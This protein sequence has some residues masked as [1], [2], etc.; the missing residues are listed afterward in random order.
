M[1]SQRGFVG[2]NLHGLETR[3]KAQKSGHR[4][5]WLRE[6]LEIG[7]FRLGRS[8]HRHVSSGTLWIYCLL[9]WHLSL[10]SHKRKLF[11]L[12]AVSGLLRPKN[13]CKYNCSSWFRLRRAT[14]IWICNPHPFSLP[15]LLSRLRLTK[16]VSVLSY[17]WSILLNQ[18]S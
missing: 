5:S 13:L 2:S 14:F 18:V 8:G 10:G 4:R 1:N 15:M 6:S 17:F 3:L 16:N 7:T 12:S 9:V 11:L